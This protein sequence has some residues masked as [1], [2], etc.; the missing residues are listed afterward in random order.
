VLRAASGREIQTWVW[1]P[2]ASSKGS[3]LFGHGF[4]S[5]PLKYEALISTWVA[6]GFTVYAPLH[7]DSSEHPAKSAYEGMD[8]W[9]TRVEDMQV[10][11]NT[12]VEENF[13]A[14]GHSYGAL[15]AL[16]AG[17][18]EALKPDNSF[19]SQRDPRAKLVLAFSPPGQIP[20]LVT[21]QGFK[22]IA[23]PA[24]IQTGKRDNPPGG[25]WESHLDAFNL[26]SHSELH[27][28]IYENVDHYFGGAIC[29]PE[30]PGPKQINELNDAASVSLKMIERYFRGQNRGKNSEKNN[31]NLKI[32]S[33]I[34]SAELMQKS[35][36]NLFGD[37]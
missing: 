11:A 23:V 33:E 7:V 6:A 12:Y 25:S 19:G 8:S 3:I 28:L 14:A 32:D 37:V 30:L 26:A 24:L 35:S 18:V 20:S 15:W 31:L 34:P 4:N 13:I 10:L 5:S 16:V 29:R 1:T 22:S 9:H 2:S 27:A 17:G 36:T 21:A